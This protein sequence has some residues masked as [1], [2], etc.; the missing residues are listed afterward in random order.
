MDM[1]MISG[2]DVRRLLPMSDCITLMRRT[3]IAVSTGEAAI[4][5]RTVMPLP[6]E[7]G[8]FGLMPGALAGAGFGIK[9]VSLFPGNAAAG[10]S[11]HLGLVILFEPEH[12]RPVAIMDAAEVTAIRT[13]AVSAVATALLARD[14]AGDLAILGS[15]EEAASH[16]AAIREIRQLRRVRVW[17]RTPANA[18]AFADREGA[19]HGLAIEVCADVREAVDG[20]DIVCTVTGARTPILMGDWVAP[21]AHVNAVGACTPTTAEIDAALL[22]KARFFVDLRASAEAE[23]G[24]YRA[25]RAAGLIG[26]DHIL[27]EIGEV[28]AGA[29]AGRSAAADITL[30]KSLGVAAE[31]LAAAR[32]IFD[33]AQAEDA[34][35]RFV[36]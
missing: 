16:L 4:P 24:E 19:H 31:D 2:A 15:G 34:G 25:A 1:R 29:V 33:R 27:G 10:L 18:R 35:R 22:T 14:E 36:L 3:M 11:S 23:A 6:G 26:P 12:G 28:A 9:L 21:G 13:A 7:R 5:L 20:A 32:L 8:R 30:F 17:S